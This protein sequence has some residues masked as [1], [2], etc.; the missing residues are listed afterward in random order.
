VNKGVLIMT[1]P[2]PT[3]PEGFC[4]TVVN[5]KAV[6]AV[7]IVVY[8]PVNNGLLTITVPV[9]TPPTGS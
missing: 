6:P 3:P 2:V 7:V 8:G 9:P 1:V 5:G 4:V